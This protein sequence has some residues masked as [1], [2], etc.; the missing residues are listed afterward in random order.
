MF[1]ISLLIFY[2][3]T[4]FDVRD[5]IKRSSICVCIE[6]IEKYLYRI[7]YFDERRVSSAACIGGGEDR[8]IREIGKG[9]F[10][11]LAIL[12]LSAGTEHLFIIPETTTVGSL[13]IDVETGNKKCRKTRVADTRNTCERRG[14]LDVD[15]TTKR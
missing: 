13:R 9:R 5:I 7:K 4:C 11:P 14:T 2:D 6:N 15:R 10:I 3:N 8:S 12:S 1:D